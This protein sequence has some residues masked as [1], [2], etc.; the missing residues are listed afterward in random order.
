MAA[1]LVGVTM[2]HPNGDLILRYEWCTEKSFSVAVSSLLSLELA[3]FMGD[4]DPFTGSG[5]SYKHAVVASAWAMFLSITSSLCRF[6]ERLAF[7]SPV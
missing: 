3:I 4:L 7:L 2:S 1:T 5:F 6:Q